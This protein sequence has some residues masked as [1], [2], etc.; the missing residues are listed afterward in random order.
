MTAHLCYSQSHYQ[1]LVL[2]SIGTESVWIFYILW[3][4]CNCCDRK[5][6]HYISFYISSRFSVLSFS[7][8]T[9]S[10]TDKSWIHV[11]VLRRLKSV[12]DTALINSTWTQMRT[13]RCHKR[14]S[15]GG[16]VR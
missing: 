13:T 5:Y 2:Y 3:C 16:V 7:I 1:K 8:N 11:C 12:F 9:Y 14:Q 4:K 10:A 6:H 15:S